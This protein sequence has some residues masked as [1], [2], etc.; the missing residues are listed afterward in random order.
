M[1]C[2]E[3]MDEFSDMYF[4]FDE[5]KDVEMFWIHLHHI[6]QLAFLQKQLVFF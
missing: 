4:V 5:I 6:N 3:S 2:N 1:T